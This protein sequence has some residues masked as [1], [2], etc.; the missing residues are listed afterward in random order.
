MVSPPPFAVGEVVDLDPAA[1]G[2]ARRSSWEDAQPMAS[3]AIVVV[4]DS[5]SAWDRI[6]MAASTLR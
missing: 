2:A 3:R 1:L 4:W 5:Y 6:T